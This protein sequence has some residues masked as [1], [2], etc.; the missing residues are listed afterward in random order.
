VRCDLLLS[1]LCLFKTRSQAGK[2]CEESR[3][4]VNDLPARASKEIRPG[5]RIRFRDV[6]NR[7]EEEVRVVEIPERPVS[8][9]ASRT[10]YVVLA[11][12]DVDETSGPTGPSDA[13]AA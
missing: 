4:W 10:L 12:T 11:R 9:A 3:V 8:R 7:V 5:D 6:W 13:G 2:A 1:R